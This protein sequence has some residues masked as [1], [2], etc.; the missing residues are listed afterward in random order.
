MLGFSKNSASFGTESLV[1]YAILAGMGRTKEGV[2]PAT[3]FFFSTTFG[4]LPD[5]RG[6]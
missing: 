4:E 5:Y 6:S 3:Q 1:I 2:S